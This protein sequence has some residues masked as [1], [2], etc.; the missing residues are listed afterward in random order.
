MPDMILFHGASRNDA[1]QV[2][3]RGLTGVVDLTADASLAR[4]F[5]RYRDD[6][7]VVTVKVAE[8]TDLLA[9][10]CSCCGGHCPTLPYLASEAVVSVEPVAFDADALDRIDRF[11]GAYAD[12]ATKPRSA[13]QSAA[14][15]AVVVAGRAT[16]PTWSEAI[17]EA[18][19]GI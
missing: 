9:R 8:G 6:G 3:D 4:D 10:A 5:A 7:L 1:K 14:V 13:E 2:R 12:E 15:W 16:W 17:D 19:K 18:M 11:V